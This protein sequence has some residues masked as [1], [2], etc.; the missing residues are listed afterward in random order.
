MNVTFFGHSDTPQCIDS[1]LK[2]VLI[3]LIENEDAT[4]FYVGNN[5]NF[6]VIVRN[7]LKSLKSVY[8]QINYA[9][10]LSYMPTRKP[11]HQYKDYFDTIYPDI[12]ENVPPRFAISKRNKWMIEQCDLVITYVNSTVGGAYKFKKLAEKR[13]KKIINLAVL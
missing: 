10:V 8:P 3:N 6:D 5:G 7:T 13:G 11:E 2:N 1:K 9:V 12:F 4:M